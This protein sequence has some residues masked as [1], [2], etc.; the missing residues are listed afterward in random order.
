MSST[1]LGPYEI[2]APLGA[3][4]MGEV[5]R[6][7]DTRLGREVAVKVLPEPF[8][9]E[10]DRRAR[11]EREARAVAALSH[12]NI[13]AIH[14]YGSEGAVTY[15]VM[16]LLEGETLRSRL[17]RG[18]LP[19]REAVEVGAAIADGLGS[20][21]ARG[22]VHRDLKPEN[23]FLTADG[24]VKIL[25]FGLARF[26][27]M[28]GTEG[29]TSP[30]VPAQTD[31]GRVLGT[32]GYMSP[33]QVR[34]QPA[35]APS[36]LFSLGC[37]L[38]EMVAGRRAFRRETAAETMTAILHDE[39]PDPSDSGSPL[40]VELVRLIRYCLAKALN[41]RLH[42][43]RDLALALRATASNPDLPSSAVR[44]AVEAVAVLP[45]ENVGGDPK[46]EYLS[47]GLVDQLTVPR[48][49]RRIIW[50]LAALLLAA[51][52]GLAVYLVIKHGNRPEADTQPPD[53]IAVLPF[54][55]TGN[56]PKTEELRETLADHIIESLCQVR[57]RDLHIRPSSSVARYARQRPDNRE[58]GTALNVPLLVTGR[59]RHTGENDLKI[60]VEVVDARTDN[61]IWFDHYP[62]KHGGVLD[63]DTQD[64][65]VRDVAAH[66]GIQLNE[67]EQLRL[68]TR[69]RT[70]NPEAY[71]LY[72]EAMLHFNKFTPAGLTAAI[73]SCE[74]AIEKDSKFALAH[75]ALSRC[76]I[77]RG[78]LFEGP[79]KTFPKALEH[80]NLAL[81]LDPNL[82]EAH[83]ALGAIHLFL[84]WD[85]EASERE[86]KLAI[87]LDSNVI[88]NRNIL[89][90]CLAAQGRLPEALESIKRGPKLDPLAAGRW[91]ELAMCY[92]WMG[93]SDQAIPAAQKA[94]E[95]DP[96]F[97][98]AHGE[99]GTAYLQ[100]KGMEELAVA[101]LK[102]AV[103]LGK[104]N[105]RMRGLL[106]YAYVAAGRKAEARQQLTV[107]RS[108]RRFGFAFALARI[109]AALGENEEAFKWL[110]E[111]LKERDSAV[112]WVKVDP[113]LKNLRPDL[114]F[115]E[116]LKE[117]NLPP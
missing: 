36:D 16:E 93:E 5:Y 7:R 110:R 78:A 4:G 73:A 30:Y 112:I 77:L 72:R 53:A 6:A 20:A 96:R 15:A 56:D 39:P 94:I 35:E 69:R 62:G 106:G 18:P 46:T 40:P 42:S 95:L 61:V 45:F 83:S 68:L 82:P 44:P 91:N 113:M 70:K 14:D 11:F 109:H 114:Q 1:R 2:V 31:P 3:G 92:N 85:W 33:E 67:E 26:E 25:D 50:G 43:A 9:N 97:F 84:D 59:I 22:I 51:L 117:M 89:G 81:K 17:A 65:I 88:L 52:I 27:P 13:L 12:P 99:L 116:V 19:W 76:L 71:Q 58:I 74:Q 104:G 100:K 80:V 87:D 29:E 115:A 28:A 102:T 101:T 24:R 57:R 105:P 23:L 98:L 79:R 8:A 66:L 47:D 108:E 38:Y 107:L 111:A 32:V 49:P 48:R 37:V 54:E 75:V 21:H 41:Q 34:S 10:A 55:Y 90:F 86:L 103:E 64:R 60:T 63:L